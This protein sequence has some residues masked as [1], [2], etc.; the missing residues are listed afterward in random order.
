MGTLATKL[1]CAAKR[2]IIPQTL[3]EAGVKG[4]GMIHPTWRR[5]KNQI[6]SFF[7][8]LSPLQTFGEKNHFL[9]LS[10]D[11]LRV[12]VEAGKSFP[13]LFSVVAFLLH[14][15]WLRQMSFAY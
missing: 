10:F 8:V 9:F 7:I 5:V 1:P 6:S 4:Q 12:C 13:S 11:F 14:L 2:R 15:N 3:W